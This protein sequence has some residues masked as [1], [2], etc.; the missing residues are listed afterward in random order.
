MST[1]E[2]E[3]NA[4]KLLDPRFLT[5]TGKPANQIAF[6]VIREDNGVE[7]MQTHVQRKRV[8]KRADP[9]LRIDFEEGATEEMVREEMSAYGFSDYNLSEE[10]GH[11]VVIRKE[12]EDGADTLSVNIGNGRMAT[13]LKPISIHSEG[14]QFGLTVAR[15]EFAADYFV[16]QEEVTEWLTRNSVDF[17]EVTMENEGQGTVVQRVSLVESA[18]V[19]RIQVD[20][21]VQFVIS[22]SAVSDI[23]ADFVLVVNDAA[24]GNW[25]WGQL[26]FGAAMADIEFCN[27]A[28]ESTRVLRDI[29]DRILFYSD[30]PVSV[31]KDLLANAATQFATFVGGLLD[32]LP[33]R[34]VIATRSMK[35][36]E[37]TVKTAAEIQ[38]EKDAAA[39]AAR[40]E[41][42][43]PLADVVVEGVEAPALVADAAPAADADQTITRDEVA[44]MITAAVVAALAT[45]SRSEPVAEA[46]A[47]VAAPAVVAETP[48]VDPASAA[49]IAAM[50]TIVRSMEE[51][52]ERLAQLEG[53]TVARSD[54]Q[55]ALQTAGKPDLFVGIFGK[56]P[57]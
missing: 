11:F 42:E 1:V 37:N 10:G 44:A 43:A 34:V 23:P 21:G 15:V 18:E 16:S 17:S 2:K 32:A 57:A 8:A 45:V 40:S 30:L 14:E 3:V 47:V 52:T 35:D 48:A 27:L 13:I 50:S 29:A 22:R 51:M 26:D 19:R 28:D 39:L 38:A 54:G 9:L 6:K 24:Y 7:T 20:D 46:E 5:L 49:T 53:T 31:R 55:D 41:S 12:P 56:K 36:K 25:G 4:T 33:A